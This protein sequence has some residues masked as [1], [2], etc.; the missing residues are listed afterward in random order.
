MEEGREQAI[1]DRIRVPKGGKSTHPGYLNPVSINL[2]LCC[3]DIPDRE[4]SY[5]DIRL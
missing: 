1:R 5:Q 2:P 3:N 4:Q